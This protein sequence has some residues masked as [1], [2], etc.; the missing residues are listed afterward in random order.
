[1]AGAAGRQRKFEVVF[2]LAN[3]NIL[4]GVD[5][6]PDTSTWAVGYFWNSTGTA[7]TLIE[8]LTC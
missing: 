8:R 1:M 6:A 4:V 5:S 2:P 7:R 3:D